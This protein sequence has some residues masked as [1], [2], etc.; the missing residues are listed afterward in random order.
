MSTFSPVMTAVIVFMFFLYFCVRL[1]ESEAASHCLLT[2]FRKFAQQPLAEKLFILVFIVMMVAHG[3]SKSTNSVPQGGGGNMVVVVN[4]GTV[5]DGTATDGTITIVTVTNAAITGGSVTGGTVTNDCV[6]AG[7]ATNGVVTGGAATNGAFADGGVTGA[8]T[9]D[10]TGGV[11]LLAGMESPRLT[12]NQYAAGFALV[13]ANTNDAVPWLA[14]PSNGAVHAPWSRY[15]VAEDT[16]WLPTNGWAFVLGTNPVD[17][18]HVSSSGTLSFGLPKGSPRAAEMPDGTNINFF[19]PLQARLGTVPPGGRFWYAVS[20]SNS[21]LCTWQ[22]VYAGRDS[23]SVAS[24]QAELFWN[25]DFAYRYAFTNAPALTNFVVGAQNRGGGETYALDAT[26]LLVNGLELHWRAF[27]MLD[28]GVDDHDGDGLSTYDEVMLYGTNPALKDTDRDGLLEDAAELAAGADPRNPDTDGDGLADGI[29]PLPTVWNDT[30]A[31]IP[32][33]GGLTYG[34][35]IL[36]GLD[37]ATNWALDSDND[38]WPDWKE[39]MAGTSPTDPYSTPQNSDGSCKLFDATF[40]LGA[41]LPCPVVLNVGGYTLILQKAGSWTLTLKEGEAYNL[42]LT[43]SQPCAVSPSC[44]LTSAFAALQDA[45]GAFSGGAQLPGGVP[46]ACGVIAQPTVSVTP[47]PPERVC[48]HSDAPE[49]VAAKVSPAMAGAYQ[50]YWYGGAISSASGKSANISWDG[51]DS[52][53]YLSFTASGATQPR[54]AYREVT[55]CSKVGDGAWCDDHGCE[56][57][58]CA[59]DEAGAEDDDDCGFHGQKVSKCRASVCPTH[60]CPYD[61]CPDGWCHQHDTW[62]SDCGEWWCHMHECYYSE[63]NHE[64][65]DPDED[66]EG[67]GG[68]EEEPD[69]D[70]GE[71]V[72]GSCDESLATVNNDDD[73]ASGALDSGE[74]PVGVENDLVAVWP[75]GHFDGQCCPCPE[76]HVPPDGSQ[77]AEL[78]SCSARLALYADAAKTSAQGDTVN[79]GQAVWVEGRTASTSVGADRIVWKWTDEDNHVH[80]VTNAFTVLSVR[81]FGDVN[82][83]GQVDA[84]DKALHPA[85][86]HEYG[87]GMPA[88]TNVFPPVVL[89]TDVGLSGGVYTLALSGPSGMC[90]IWTTGTPSSTNSP[91][92]VCGQTVTNGVNGVCFLSGADSVLYVEA[93]GG[94]TA[95]LT[96]QYVG[97]GG[98]AGISCAAAMKLSSVAIGSVEMVGAPSDGLVV[99]KG[100]NVTMKA[101]ISP[102]NY[103]L[104]S[105]EPTWYYQQLKLDGT[106]EN[107]NSFGSAAN[108]IEYAHTTTQSGVF[109]IKAVLNLGGSV[110]YT[111]LFERTSNENSGPGLVGDAD[112]IGVVDAQIQI[113]LRNTAKSYL[114]NASYARYCVVPAL[115]GFPEYPDPSWKC[116][117]FV[118][119]RAM[120]VGATV[121]AINGIPATYPPTANEW[122]GTEDTHLFILGFQNDI[123]NWVLLPSSAYPQPGFIIGHPAA[124]GSG[125]C[126]IVDYDGRGIGAGENTVNKNYYQFLDGTSGLRVY[127][128]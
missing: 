55:K 27:G 35:V 104:P 30:G 32:N 5:A 64:W 85:L 112:A 69:P 67:G 98:A 60:D 96:Y 34:R 107:W 73:D 22:N 36:N 62:Y 1:A 102:A 65:Y 84:A 70:P 14:L 99:L 74:S 115:F 40:T 75:L 95:T 61:E 120:Q 89:R 125:H 3:G 114:G 121:P 108:G 31:V 97:T 53:V 105:G 57:W 9:G 113:A 59:C 24:F 80:R 18:V 41:D 47:E 77:S 13:R 66:P 20:P 68:S 25:G 28:P 52:Y 51:G 44:S 94:G 111:R 100:G 2:L 76:H 71:P 6:T 4:P 110:L 54:F 91:L 56:H 48:F 117:I 86:S 83:D 17:G 116:N 8:L 87:W 43:A 29:D 126:G 82:L 58:Y 109:R 63:R 106:W 79:A 45:S 78:E 119:H 81:L 11:A 128:P 90:R 12:T 118:A 42:T 37:P 15:G 39:L 72:F 88:A 10:G 101:N 38:G 93:A 19:A 127:E 122:A 50:W 21:L 123:D 7:T 92:L 124:S 26:N 49:T 103:P 46:A 23:N 16:F 33:S